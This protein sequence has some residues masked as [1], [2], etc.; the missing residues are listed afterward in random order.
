MPSL[1]TNSAIVLGF[2]M[3]FENCFSLIILSFK[4]VKICADDAGS[5]G[6]FNYIYE[7]VF[8]ILKLFTISLNS[9][10]ISLFFS[11]PCKLARESSTIFLSISCNVKI[12]YF[13][14]LFSSFRYIVSFLKPSLII[15][16]SSF[17]ISEFSIC[18]ALESG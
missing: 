16:L 13:N 9:Y 6:T 7:M 17:M 14:T 3:V 10:N 15:S 4:T 18:V 8:V 12:F 2:K 11:T 5:Y 1:R